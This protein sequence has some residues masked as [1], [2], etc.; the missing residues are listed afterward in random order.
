MREINRR[1]FGNGLMAAAGLSALSPLTWAEV[2]KGGQTQSS[3]QPYVGSITDVPGIRVGHFTDT[4]RP[5]GCTVLLFE[6]KGAATGVDFDGSAPGTYQVALLQPVSF[7][8]EIWGICLSGG[9]SFG[10]QSVPG[11]V[12]YLEEQKVGLGFG[13]GLVPIVV[14]AIIYDLSVG[15]GKIRP[16]A[17]SAYKACLV[18]TD[19]AT[20]QGNVGAGAGGT[21]GKMLRREGYG[22]MKSGLG[23]A[24]LRVGDVVIGALMVTNPVGDIVDWRTGKVAAG[25]RSKDQKGFAR[26]SDV[27][28]T[29]PP[30]SGRAA[31]VPED[32]VMQ[33]TTIGV[34]ATNA[35]FNKTEMTKIAMMANC[36]AARTINPY[37]TP[38]DGDTL[39]GVSTRKIQS[40]LSLSVIGA[41][42]AEVVS[43]AVL[44]S[45]KTASTIPDWP[46][47]RDYTAKL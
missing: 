10:L 23:M 45:V 35:T 24:S 2:Q 33:A 43:E 31:F 25:A 11:V 40:E 41:L 37:H 15:D 39:F 47:Y 46:A 26:I 4:R 5:T 28:K 36:G 7:I 38:G 13:V 32:P 16:D 34:V 9:S 8:Q 44:Q 1:Q 29:Q 19:K 6:E 3:P 12:R 30:K 42:A 22:G 17:E 14:G 18:A 20:E 21:C 27:L